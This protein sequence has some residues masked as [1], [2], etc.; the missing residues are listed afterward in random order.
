LAKMSIPT[1]VRSIGE[2]A[3][4]YCKKLVEFSSHAKT[5]PT[6]SDDVF[7]NVP[8]CILYVPK[9]SKS[10]YSESNWNSYFSTIEEME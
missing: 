2:A 3:F 7:V 4:G 9:G 1:S 5:P 10:A 6:L 8:D